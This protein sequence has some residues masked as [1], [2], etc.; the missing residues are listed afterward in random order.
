M[1]GATAVPWLKIII[2]P[3]IIKI[4]NIG[5]NQYFFLTFK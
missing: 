4:S 1:N 3:K 2:P 5:T